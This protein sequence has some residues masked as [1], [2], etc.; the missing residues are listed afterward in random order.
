MSTP[1]ILHM[2]SPAE[3]VSPFDVNMAADAGFEI[4]IP[5]TGVMVKQVVPLVQDAIFSRPPKRFDSTGVFI[6]G[7][8]INLAADMLAEAKKAQVP[9]FEVGLFA[10]PNGAYTT[11]AALVALVKH[12]LET[13]T[14]QGLAGRKVVIYG[15]GPVGLCTAVLVA[16]QGGKPMLARL[17]PSSPEKE[18][19]VTQFAKR[20]DVDLPGVGAQSE[21]QKAETLKDAEV[22]IAA[23]KAGIQ[24]LSKDLLQQAPQ[25]LVAADVNAVP[26]PGVEGLGVQDNGAALDGTD[27]AVGIGALAIGNIK[28]KV[29]HGLF[30]RMLEADKAQVLDFPDAYQLASEL[31]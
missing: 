8:D 28:Y 15:G 27:K 12:H 3:R 21:A 24:V 14:G 6:G 29:Q 23:A 17:T 20:Y 30:K 18:Q 10:D 16:Q 1:R 25:L 19:I 31:V 2:L 22:I 11:S 13:K 9:P 7:H 26:P 4:I 5:Y